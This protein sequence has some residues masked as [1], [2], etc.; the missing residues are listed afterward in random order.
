[1]L[2]WPSAAIG[3]SIHHD[4]RIVRLNRQGKLIEN[5]KYSLTDTMIRQGEIINFESWR[6]VLNAACRAKSLALTIDDNWIEQQR[7]VIPH[8]HRKALP[9]LIKQKIVPGNAYD[10]H[11]YQDHCT[12]WQLSKTR[13][14]SYVHLAKV[15]GLRL[16]SIESESC[17]QLRLFRQNLPQ[18][19]G[20]YH[21]STLYIIDHDTL[22]FSHP[23]LNDEVEQGIALYEKLHPQTITQLLST[24]P[25]AASSK[26]SVSMIQEPDHINPEY[27]SAY[28]AA[29]R[30]RD[31]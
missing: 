26:L 10:Y 14:Q 24:R 21:H 12:L 17:A 5:I 8:T 1:M 2:Y 7:F 11:L 15:L 28:A 27:L 4:L 18:P 19:Y 25:V 16:K 29:R 22:I 13:Y 20:I 3:M 6:T 9:Y 31:V 30:M 23:V